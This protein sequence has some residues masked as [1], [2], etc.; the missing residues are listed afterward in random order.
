MVSSWPDHRRLLATL[1]AFCF[2]RQQFL[3][4]NWEIVWEHH[5][6]LSH[7]QEHQQDGAAE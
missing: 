3:A 5:K 2:P 4:I 1:P 6:T 7:E